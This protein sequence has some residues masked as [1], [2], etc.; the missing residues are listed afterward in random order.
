MDASLLREWAPVNDI[1]SK[2]PLR[3]LRGMFIT[4]VCLT[5]IDAITEYIAIGTN[6]GFAIWYDRKKGDFI[7]LKCE[8]P[9][10]RITE[11][12]VVSSVEY[13]V[14]C[15]ADNGL[16]SVFSI[17][18]E[19]PADLVRNEFKA[20]PPERYCI[21]DLHTSS[22]TALEWSKNGMKLFSGDKSGCVVLTEIDFYMHIC[23]SVELVNESYEI[24]QLCFNNPK[25]II[26]TSFRTIITEQK[27]LKWEV[28]QIGRQDRKCLSK[29]G[30]TFIP[31]SYLKE[32]TRIYNCR[33]GHRLWVAKLDG[34]VDKTI[35]FKDKLRKPK[36]TV[37]LLNPK[38][39]SGKDCLALQPELPN[40]GI[41]K[42]YGPYLLT[43]NQQVMYL[44][45][46]NGPEVLAVLTEFRDILS[47]SIIDHEIFILEGPRSLIRIS[48]APDDN[49]V[50]ADN[51]IASILTPST[52]LSKLNSKLKTFSKHLEDNA[53]D[54]EEVVKA[55][56]CI[57]LPPIEKLSFDELPLLEVKENSQDHFSQNSLHY[58]KLCT[59]DKINNLDYDEN[60]LYK[61]EIRKKR[62]IIH[63]EVENS[64]DVKTSLASNNMSKSESNYR[65]N[66]L[67]PLI[68]KKN[69]TIP[70][71]RSPTSILEDIKYKENKLAK[72]L[73]L[74]KIT[75]PQKQNTGNEDSDKKFLEDFQKVLQLP[76]TKLDTL[77]NCKSSTEEISNG[78][79]LHST[80]DSMIDSPKQSKTNDINFKADET[81]ISGKTPNE[82][83]DHKNRVDDE[84]Y[85]KIPNV[86]DIP[87]GWNLEN[88][89]ISSNNNIND[90]DKSEPYESLNTK[91]NDWEFL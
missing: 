66:E 5:C 89:H 88:I 52:I 23:K 62:K 73:N 25:L 45:D 69:Y 50:R 65:S 15:G 56:E 79:H 37:P 31:S 24:V 86:I 74:E 22:I 61:S 19:I 14:A 36:F 4:D 85:I 80:D 7:R 17:P 91:E 82:E 13:M 51:N 48:T 90:L 27:T 9:T 77:E 16:I 26:S 54:S 84:S 64:A 72:L 58:T 53:I 71:L 44:L 32:R 55:E 78:H 67:E 6:A 83:T 34:S 8:E 43:Y 76:R 11:I 3:W 18:K 42:P 30:A 33:L 46:P 2:I 87:G 68:L 41:I 81:I 49:I 35:L 40:F 75:I 47:V 38:P 29:L 28:L 12:K 70:D 1:I 63:S 21:R 39:K 57:E 20:N 59:F 10:N 60:I